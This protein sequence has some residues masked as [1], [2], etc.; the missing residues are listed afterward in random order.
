MPFILNIMKSL[1]VSTSIIVQEFPFLAQ[2]YLVFYEVKSQHQQLL[3]YQ[4]Q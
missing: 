2:A 4:N 3:C 1:P